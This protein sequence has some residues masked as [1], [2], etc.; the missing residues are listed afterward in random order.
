[1]IKTITTLAGAYLN[2]ASYIM[3]HIAAKHGLQLFCRP[4]RPSIKDYHK[5]FLTSAD[6]FSFDYDGVAIQGYRWGNGSKKILF[7]HGWQSHTFRWKAY[8]ESLSKD[9]YSIYAID[10]PGHGLSGGSYL[11]VPYYGALIQHLLETLGTVHTIVSHSLGSFS[12]LYAFY[13]QPLLPVNNLILLA[14]PGEAS[15]FFNFYK[16]KLRLS[17]KAIKL[18]LGEF[19][20]VFQHPI[21]HFSTTKLAANIPVPGLIIHDEDDAE[22]SYHYATKIN[23]AWKNSTLITTKGLGHNLKSSEVVETITKFISDTNLSIQNEDN[24]LYLA[25]S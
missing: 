14:P 18:I 25:K 13:Q 24:T 5:K 19:E 10:A 21:S 3:P 16:R 12:A 15:D 6:L 9:E 4:I 23:Q 20:R 17:T 8:V 22:T 1:M 2:A 11:S 7:L